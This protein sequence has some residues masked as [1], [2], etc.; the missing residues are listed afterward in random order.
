MQKYGPVS[1][2]KAH[3]HL[4]VGPEE[5]DAWLR[6]MERAV[7]LQP[8]ED[9]FKKY[10]IEQLAIPAERIRVTSKN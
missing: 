1:I 9:S 6:C 2:P 3:K 7:A 4:R 8:Y 10:L 5:R